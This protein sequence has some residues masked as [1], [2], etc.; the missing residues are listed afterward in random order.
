[1]KKKLIWLNIALA[2]LIAAAS[3]KVTNEWSE[4]KKRE[5]AI[6]TV[7]VK[8]PPVKPVVV[9]PAPAPVTAGSYSDIATKMLFS[10][11][12]NP[13]V[14]VEVPA[15]PK[16]VPVPPLPLLQGIMGMPDGMLALM[17]VKANTRAVGITVGEKIGDFQLIALSRD[18]ISFKWEDKT[19]TKSVSEMIYHAQEQATAAA[20]PL[21]QAAAA[22]PGAQ[23]ASPG[24]KVGA[25]VVGLES[26][27]KTCT[28]GDTSPNGTLSDGYK[29]FL[30]PT[31][32]GNSCH[33]ELVK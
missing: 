25:Q 4:Q 6:R 3:Y 21:Q 29:K 10:Q 16:P 18:E 7:R 33:W 26:D 9:P 5:Q 24:G 12:R 27:F 23:A 22:A 11:E 19:I 17:S 20:P 30:V 13:T 8:A 31:P 28:P 32:F 2:G 14:V 1:M 15:P